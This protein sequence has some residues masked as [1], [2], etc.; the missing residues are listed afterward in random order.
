MIQRFLFDGVNLQCRRRSIP[1]VI[2][3]AATID[4]N[5]AKSG[6]PIADVAVARAQEAMHA[7]VWHGLPPTPFVQR[8]RVLQ[9][10]QAWHRKLDQSQ[11]EDGEPAARTNL[12]PHYTRLRCFCRLRSGC[13][14]RLSPPRRFPVYRYALPFAFAVTL[15][16]SAIPAQAQRTKRV[17]TNADMD[18][19]RALG[20]ISIVGPETV[21]ATPAAPASATTPS[22]GQFPVYASRTEDP[23][24]YA[25]QAADLQA[26][27]NAGQTALTQAQ[28][29]LAQAIDLRG[30]TGTFNMAAGDTYGVTPEDRI[31]FLAARVQE[32]QERLDELA[33]LA[34]RNDIPPG[35]LRGTPA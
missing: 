7:A 30:T 13:K 1:Q 8:F 14:L 29:N 21:A 31:A 20:L 17:W 2:E 25:N 10:F 22:A 32:T 28:D 11:I 15:A 12:W 33:D 16:C 26:Q 5:E 6:L 4:A 24:W 35:V 9:N 19:L 27:L 34:R 18:D 23:V 3:L